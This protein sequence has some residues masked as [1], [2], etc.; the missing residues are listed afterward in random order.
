MRRGLLLRSWF[1]FK[2]KQAFLNDTFC[3]S[4]SGRVGVEV[5]Q[6]LD[7]KIIRPLLFIFD[8]SL[9]A[10]Q[11]LFFRTFCWHFKIFVLFYAKQKVPMIWCQNLYYRRYNIHN[12]FVQRM[13][14]TRTPKNIKPTSGQNLVPASSHKQ[15]S[16]THPQA[17]ARW[18]LP[19][20]F[21]EMAFFC[22]FQFVCFVQYDI[23]NGQKKSISL[24]KNLLIQ[25]F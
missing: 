21:N 2:I 14:D 3:N 20:D 4:E 6:H 24:I 10:V 23:S 19:P 12:K 22:C 11:L 8:R 9:F 18:E 25:W 16:P 15:G 13:Q 17:L 7:S 1:D 5:S